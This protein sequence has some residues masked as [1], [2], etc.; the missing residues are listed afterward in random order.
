[1][2]I[3]RKYLINALIFCS[4]FFTLQLGKA[5]FILNQDASWIINQGD[6]C[7]QLTPDVAWKRGCAWST[8]MI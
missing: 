8:N 5:Q 4:V 6:S 2:K 7:V 1:M 3:S